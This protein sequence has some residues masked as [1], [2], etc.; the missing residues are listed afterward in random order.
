MIEILNA[1]RIASK[2]L[3]LGT[4]KLG[5]LDMILELAVLMKHPEEDLYVIIPGSVASKP[6]LTLD[7]FEGEDLDEGDQDQDQEDLLNSLSG[8]PSNQEP[9]LHDMIT[10]LA[11]GHTWKSRE[12]IM[13]L[14][15]KIPGTELMWD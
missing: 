4:G 1:H 2:N 5:I 9:D 12:D 11:G 13:K 10:T 14:W 7:I 15:V 6:N 3:N 8:P